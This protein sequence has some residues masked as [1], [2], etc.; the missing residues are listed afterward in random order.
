MN[1][2][3]ESCDK[4]D[5]TVQFMFLCNSIFPVRLNSTVVEGSPLSRRFQSEDFSVSTYVH[6]SDI[7]NVS[8][9]VRE[10]SKF[11]CECVES[12]CSVSVEKDD[13]CLNQ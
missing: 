9:D 7:S 2:I 11:R 5:A 1:R 4:F 12:F 10:V 8:N 13:C 3:H 6:S